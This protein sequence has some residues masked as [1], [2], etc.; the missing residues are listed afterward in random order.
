[1]KIRTPNLVVAY[2]IN[3]DVKFGALPESVLGK[4]YC[5]KAQEVRNSMFQIMYKS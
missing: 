3:F 2:K 4:V 5:S 1:M